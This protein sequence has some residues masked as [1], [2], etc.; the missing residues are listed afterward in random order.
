M[1]EDT[2][3]DTTVSELFT[4]F[5]KL[6]TYG[7]INTLI[8]AVVVAIAAFALIK[9]VKRLLMRSNQGNI[10]FFYRLLKVLIILIGVF[11]VMQTITPFEQLGKTLLAGSGFVAVAV[12]IAAQS[13]LGNIFSGISIGISRPFVIGEI[14]EIVGQNIT[15]TVVEIGL[16]HTTIKDFNSKYILVPNSVIDKEI[17]RAVRHED[18]TVLNH[19]FLNVAYD[20]DIDQAIKIIK[21]AVLRHQDFYDARTPAQIKRGEKQDV[22]VIVTSLTESA[23]EL[24]ASVW[25]KDSGTGVVMLSD[26]RQIILKEFY[27]N[28]IEIPYPYRNVVLKKEPTE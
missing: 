9:L 23:V 14:I 26:L 17:I 7:F 4:A 1:P 27:E 15:G 25:S 6:F 19:L 11:I 8:L 22:I 16:R 2:L 24:R 28:G 18:K 5:N 20:T 21:N 3:L 13:S 10:K 12:G